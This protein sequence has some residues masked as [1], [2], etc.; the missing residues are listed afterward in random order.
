MVYKVHT[1]ALLWQECAG[2]GWMVY[3]E[4][5]VISPATE[6]SRCTADCKVNQPVLKCAWPLKKTRLGFHET[7]LTNYQTTLRNIPEEQRPDCSWA[8]Q[9]MFLPC[10]ETEDSLCFSQKQRSRTSTTNN[11]SFPKIRECSGLVVVVHNYRHEFLS[12]L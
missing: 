11:V 8:I 5:S 12:H 7:L 6:R 3:A 2:I 9:G 1:Y 4:I 10:M